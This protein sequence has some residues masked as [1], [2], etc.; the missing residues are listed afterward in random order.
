MLG[1]GWSVDGAVGGGSL[2]VAAWWINKGIIF[3]YFNERVEKRRNKGKNYR[4]CP[5][6]SL[7]EA[8]LEQ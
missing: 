1:A 7:L 2:V 3:P 5:K 6:N 8:F 4:Y